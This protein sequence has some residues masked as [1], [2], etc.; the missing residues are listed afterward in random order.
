MEKKEKKKLKRRLFHAFSCAIDFTRSGES[1]ARYD[2][3][4]VFVPYYPSPQICLTR[5]SVADGSDFR[6]APAALQ[7]LP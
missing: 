5:F 2:S 3:S 7:D 1:P 6:Q 4:C